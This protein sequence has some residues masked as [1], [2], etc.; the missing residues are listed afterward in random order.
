MS[1]DIS[2][3]GRGVWRVAGSLL[4]VPLLIAMSVAIA[5]PEVPPGAGP[6]PDPLKGAKSGAVVSAKHSQLYRKLLPPEIA[7]LL[8][9]G[10]LQFEAML[11]PREPKRWVA[12]KSDRT[13]IFDVT[14]SGELREIPA[15]G[16][17]SSMFEVPRVVQGDPRSLAHKI[18]WNAVGAIAQSKLIA[19]RLKI[20]IFR[21]ADADAHWVDFLVERFYPLGLGQSVGREKPF[22][23][24]KISALSP[25]AI[26]KLSWLTLRF[27]GLGEDFVWAASPMIN[28]IR[29]MT[30]SNRS[31]A[32]F[33]G[34]FSPDDLF[35][36]SGKNELVEPTSIS[37]QL[38]LVPIVAIS[39]PSAEQQ[40]PCVTRKFSGS[41]EI[42]LNADSRRFVGAGGW[43]PINTV[44]VLRDVW[45][46]EVSSR[47][48]FTN[49]V[50]QVIYVDKD[51]GL[52][53]YKVVWDQAGR[54]IKVVGGI[55]RAV[56]DEVFADHAIWGGA[57]ILHPSDGGRTIV[58]V[59]EV[60]RCEAV[61]PG[62]SLEDFDPS[63]FVIFET[64]SKGLIE[65]EKKT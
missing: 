9:V 13:D 17:R 32:I 58:M 43:V 64:Q 65:E 60:S 37:S 1:H 42:Q 38:L 35:V 54:V 36:W 59:N 56:N 61:I 47:D 18:L 28:R 26:E 41:S 10:E 46:I 31:D 50:R 48:P 12:P 3:R 25:A 29:Q 14:S 6:V 33:S 19:I 16:L 7:E 45:R 52:P 5:E 40:G 51:S 2:L 20:G 30:G 24:E 21:R 44:M 63:S 34:M 53:V 27:F 8:D 15:H 4:V 49:D 57:Y 62:K 11:Q 22:F 23:R 55:L 39:D